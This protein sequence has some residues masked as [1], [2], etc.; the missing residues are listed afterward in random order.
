MEQKEKKT[1]LKV[2]DRCVVYVVCALIIGLLVSFFVLDKK[3]FSDSENR[4]L[5]RFPKVSFESIKS[6]AFTEGI[7]T[8]VADHF[9]MRDVFLGIMTEAERLSGMKEI[10]GV[11]LAKDGS[12]IEK[13]DVPENTGKQ[14]EQFLKL[15]ED[16][17][18][19]NC[20]LMLVPTAV[21]IYKS[22]LPDNA[23]EGYS[24]QEEIQRIYN[25]VSSK[26]QTI[27]VTT[28]LRN[29]ADS[30]GPDTEESTDNDPVRLYYRT[31]H[32]WT[33]YGAYEGYKAYCDSAGITAKPLDYFEKRIV[34]E[35]FKG[36]I[37]SKLNDPYFGSDEMTSF[38]DASWNLKVEYSDN[39]DITESPYNEDY[40]DKKDKYS[41]FLNNMHP[42]VTITNNSVASGAI[43]VVKDSYA[44]SMIPFL[45][46]HYH[47]IYVFD[48]RYY[49]GGPS[50]FINQHPD[51]TDVLILYNMNTID[52]DAG[53][54]GIF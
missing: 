2:S 15:D 21:E 9:P 1:E 52:E 14:I 44:N 29:A 46:S 30:E 27:D 8:Y 41:Y 18:N 5:S 36:T 39:G 3:E 32:H 37:Y 47:T 28:N 43:A 33:T 34:S 40:L 24:Q 53:I 51:I 6:G 12:L 7:S 10:N 31:D 11:Y 17:L 23:P 45:I 35:D 25:R 48:T 19:C 50:R 49:K 26:I 42:L 4:M 54:G 20:R 13:Y 16:V 22:Q 38:S